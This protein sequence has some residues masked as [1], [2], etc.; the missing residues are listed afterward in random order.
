MKNGPITPTGS[1]QQLLSL[2]GS[3]EESLQHDSSLYLSGS[4]SQSFGD[5]PAAAEPTP[6][7]TSTL[8]PVDSAF[9]PI[10]P[11]APSPTAF[12]PIDDGPTFVPTAAPSALLPIAK[13]TDSPS[14]GEIPVDPS[15]SNSDFV[16][17]V[18]SSPK[19][20]AFI[21]VES[22]VT[23]SG[24]PPSA[25]LPVNPD[26]TSYV[27]CLA[28][29]FEM[30]LLT[31]GRVPGQDPG[32]A[33]TLPVASAPATSALLPLD[34][35]SADPGVTS[36]LIPAGSVTSGPVLTGSVTSPNN[37][38]GS[39]CFRTGTMLGEAYTV[40]E[41]GKLV[42][43]GST[44]ATGTPTTATLADGAIVEVGPTGAVAIKTPK[45]RPDQPQ[46]SI[47]PQKYVLGAFVPTILAVLFTIPW[48]I[49]AS[50]TKE[51]EPFYQL[52]LSNGAP[53]SKA[54]NLD[55]RSSVNVVAVFHALQNGHFVVWWS[56][57]IALVTL[58]LAPLA[59]E[60]IFIG[61]QGQCTATT[62]RQCYP[63]LSVYPPVARAVEGILAFVAVL[64][65]LL[66][67][68]IW[69]RSS[70]VYG[71]PL[72]LAG[73]A[74]HF[75]NWDAIEEFR[76]LNSELSAKQIAQLLRNSRYKI[77]PY[78]ERDGSH[79]YGLVPLHLTSA[80]YSQ[81]G[82]TSF[83]DGK[84]YASVSV[85]PVHEDLQ[86]RQPNKFS[87]TVVVVHPA[88]VIIYALLVAG[89]L[90]LVVY[91]NQTGGDTAFERFMDSTSFGVTALFTSIGVIIKMYWSL[92]DDQLRADEPYRALLAGSARAD[93]SILLAPHSNPFTGIFSSVKHK[94]WFNAYVSLVAILCEPLIVA[95]ANI[96][97]K[98]ALSLIAYRTATYVTI[99]VLSMMILG[100]IV[101]L[102]RN[103]RV[104]HQR[105]RWQR[106][107][108]ETLAEMMLLMS[109]SNMLGDFRGLSELGGEERNAVVRGWGKA[110][111][112]GD[113][114][115]VD[116]VTR[117]G[118]DD[119]LFVRRDD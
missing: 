119:E 98:P 73:V 59:P 57:L 117:W 65:L 63:R 38:T 55:Y 62:G 46:K 58:V 78:V 106:Q 81:A 2:V 91:Y 76:R 11:P 115:G 12:L 60:T 9:L 44:F 61:F 49:L 94:H 87:S 96:P 15:P 51:L 84:E 82:E 88:T 31:F 20:S 54:L 107:R 118:V 100:V 7:A 26:P 70:G 111:S 33:K 103:C 80:A 28:A 85:N 97:Y 35:T 4:F 10:I 13:P 16:P 40:C 77:G 47:T 43:G 71:N 67:I 27:K 3:P 22:G 83:R 19:D 104:G 95:L 113:V 68:V 69:R 114:A 56:G 8:A 29:I 116:G 1:V 90:T 5:E 34:S 112:M 66:A 75:Q 25:L 108:P 109:G 32:T 101:F 37:P 24:V 79:A 64:T 18:A 21:P 53:V 23:A 42:I 86:P 39:A 99:G 6:D 52:Q 72:S 110:Y 41:G 93:E 17:I 48:H 105:H 102:I 92:L 36:G 89:L 30:T 14:E 74:T 50:A 45:E